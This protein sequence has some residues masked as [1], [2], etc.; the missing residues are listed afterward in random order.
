[1]ASP[2]SVQ[3]ANCGRKAL[4]QDGRLLQREG[5][6]CPG[7]ERRTRGVLRVFAFLAPAL[8]SWRQKGNRSVG[9]TIAVTDQTDRTHRSTSSEQVWSDG[10]IE[11]T[12][13]G[14]EWGTGCSITA[15]PAHAVHIVGCDSTTPE[16]V[17]QAIAHATH[18]LHSMR[19]QGVRRPPHDRICRARLAGLPG[20]RRAMP[21]VCKG[22][23]PASCATTFPESFRVR[24]GQDTRVTV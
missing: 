19:P 21:P 24:P 5:W 13:V 22:R 11:A 1:M 23:R 9:T 14:R 16:D 20:R 12:H 17:G 7:K 6:A 10:R 8:V 2:R 15:C 4:T 18:D 3:C